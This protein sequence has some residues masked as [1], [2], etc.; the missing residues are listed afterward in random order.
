MTKLVVA[1]F[2]LLGFLPAPLL[3]LLGYLLGLIT[4]PLLVRRRQIVAVNLQLCFP[5]KSWLWRF[6]VSLGHGILLGRFFLDHALWLVASKQRMRR[7]VTVTGEQHLPKDTP[8]ILLVPHFLGLDAGFARLLVE[9]DVCATYTPQHSQIME[10][11]SLGGRLRHSNRSKEATLFASTDKVIKQVVT[12]ITNKQPLYYLC[13]LDLRNSARHVFVPFL[14]T[15]AAT[16]TTLP[17][18]A[19]MTNAVVVPCVTKL[20]LFG[21]Y[22]V[23]LHAPWP[24]FP[25]ADV[26]ADM[27]RFNEF[28]GR[29][30]INNPT[31]YYWVHRRFKTQ[32]PGHPDPYA[33]N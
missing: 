8:V 31:Q 16:I 14:A 25:T 7:L 28:V 29:E 11:I 30:V 15:T 32:P 9:H 2:S 13:D 23:C 21:G 3:A 26:T 22:E 33:G 10:S 24:D 1:A 18:L 6:G 5:A 12:S 17:R 20:R 27:T 4:W 19:K